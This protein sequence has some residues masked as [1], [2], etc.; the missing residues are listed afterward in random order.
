MINISLNRCWA[1]YACGASFSSGQIMTVNPPDNDPDA[2]D[3]VRKE[4]AFNYDDI[5]EHTG[6]MGKFQRRTCLL[7]FIAAFF[8]SWPVMNFTFIGSV[9]DYK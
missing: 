1:V 5:L 3:V 6:Q 4:E 8:P 2:F 9:P 7:L